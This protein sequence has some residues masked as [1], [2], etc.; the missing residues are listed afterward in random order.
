MG[1]ALRVLAIAESDAE[2]NQLCARHDAWAVVACLGPWVLIADKYDPGTVIPRTP[3]G[4][5][6]GGS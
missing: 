3:I 2:A 4:D 6:T 1:K 5:Q